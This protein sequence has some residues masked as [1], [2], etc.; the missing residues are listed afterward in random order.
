MGDYRKRTVGKINSRIVRW[1]TSTCGVQYVINVD[2]DKFE[3]EHL[4]TDED[5]HPT[6]SYYVSWR[7]HD[8]I[9]LTTKVLLYKDLYCISSDYPK[10]VDLINN[11]ILEFK[12]RIR[13]AGFDPDEYYYQKVV[14]PIDRAIDAGQH[15]P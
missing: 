9:D 13:N 1:D 8:I 12:Q 4:E 10:L 3:L 14:A 6:R 2:L 11:D 7:E 5:V 15:G